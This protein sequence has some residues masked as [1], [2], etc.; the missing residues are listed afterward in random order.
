MRLASGL[1]LMAAF[2]PAQAPQARFEAAS[3]RL[4]QG[5]EL[6]APSGCPTD[7]ILVRCTNVTLKRAIVGAYDVIPD[8]VLGGPD[9][10][11]SDRF[12]ITAKSA[13]PVRGEELDKML[14]A[15][16]ADRFHLKF[17]REMRNL[18]A[19][20]LGIAKNGP[21]LQPATGA[22]R[23]YN[24]A[25][26]HMEASGVTMSLFAEVLSRQLG[27]PVM[28]RTGL[29]GAFNFR[30]V[31]NPDAPLTTELGTGAASDAG[32]D[33]FNSIKQQLGLTLKSRRMRVEVLMVDHAERP[34]A[35]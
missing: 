13:Q 10:I 6:D 20:V 22:P 26:G 32:V 19:F 3:I 27:L 7:A 21:K 24:N 18:P 4:S 2:L 17:H 33:F 12:Q 30:L 15:L 23:S 5:D 9:W 29:T 16:L 35:D 31:W 28:D 1:L 11:D 8:R 25:H 14:Q 34:A